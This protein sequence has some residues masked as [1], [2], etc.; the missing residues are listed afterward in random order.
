MLKVRGLKKRFGDPDSGLRQRL[1][2][3]KIVFLRRHLK[4]YLF[5]GHETA[6]SPREAFFSPSERIPLQEACGRTAAC[7]VA[8]YPPGIPVLYPGEVITEEICRYLTDALRDGCHVHGIG[9][10]G[11]IFFIS[12]VTEQI[13][14]ALFGMRF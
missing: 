2:E 13:C 14:S 6:L 4:R 8:V 3:E 5:L 9:Q 1:T 11:G 12:V 7:S 10:E